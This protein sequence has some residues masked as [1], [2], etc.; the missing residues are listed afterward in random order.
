MSKFANILG[1]ALFAMLLA[2]AIG[3]PTHAAPMP[4]KFHLQEATIQDI[5]QSIQSGS[6]TST[7]I[8]TLYLKRIK[9]YNGTCVKQPQGILGPIETIPNA[10]QINALSTLNLRPKTRAKWGFDARKARSMT[11]SVDNL[12]LIHI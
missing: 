11:D 12:S 7:D 3:T 10:G 8:V 6:L 4:G 9:A 2:L 1:G 5:Q